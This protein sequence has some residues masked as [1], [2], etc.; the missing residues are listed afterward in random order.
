MTHVLG[1]PVDLTQLLVIIHCVSMV[2]G[3][4]LMFANYE[5]IVSLFV[6][7]GEG[8]LKGRFWQL[9]TYAFVQFPTLGFVL[10]MF[11]LWICGREVEHFIGR[12]AY[13]TLYLA[14]ILFPSLTLAGLTMGRNIGLSGSSPIHL[15][16]FVA[17][18]TIY[19]NTPT[20]FRIPAKYLAMVYV[21]ITS[22]QYMA[23]HMTILLLVTWLCV[24]IAFLAMRLVGISGGFDWLQRWL[25]ERKFQRLQKERNFHIVKS[26]AEEVSIDPI[27]EKISK[28]GMSSLSASERQALNRA[29]EN[30]LKKEKQ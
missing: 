10:E 15:G 14:L 19:P 17:F 1:Y 6:F 4:F 27:L 22:L 28:Q 29:R 8:V 30:L 21:A 24:A 18:A 3:A 7:S 9:F 2:A 23:Y 13:V 5:S 16:I 26:E 25:A 11:M 12:R 20:F